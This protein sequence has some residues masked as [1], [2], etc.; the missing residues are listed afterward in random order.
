M[1]V[2]SLVIR[3]LGRKGRQL[4]D[5]FNLVLDAGLDLAEQGSVCPGVSFADK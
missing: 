2:H 4:A 1:R 5:G 3:I